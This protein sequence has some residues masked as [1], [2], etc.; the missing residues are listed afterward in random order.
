MKLTITSIELRNPLLYFVLSHQAL[1]ITLQLRKTNCVKMKKRGLW[2]THYTMTLWE[3]EADL[4]DFARSGA[5]FKYMKTSGKIAKAIKTLTID[6]T[7][8][9]SWKEARAM[10][11]TVK[12]IK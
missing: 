7:E 5:H 4:K 3:N 2:T 8:M 9:P 6:A 11:A 12:P 1:F 10:L